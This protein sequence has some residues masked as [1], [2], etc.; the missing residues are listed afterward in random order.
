[1]T[2]LR[3]TKIKPI[4]KLDP[5]N[6]LFSSSSDPEMNRIMAVRVR[7]KR[8]KSTVDPIAVKRT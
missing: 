8:N 5:K 2:K 4:K 7:P 6:C 3:I 1:M